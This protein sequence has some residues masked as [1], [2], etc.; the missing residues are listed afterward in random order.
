MSQKR[1]WTARKETRRGTDVVPTSHDDIQIDD[2]ERRQLNYK[3]EYDKKTYRQISIVFNV[4]TEKE[5]LEF[6]DKAEESPK[7]LLAR[8]ITEDMQ[9]SKE[10][11]RGE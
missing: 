3:R 8:L 5:M 11:A 7:Q 2:M 4:E 10:T 1:K 6:I 9:K